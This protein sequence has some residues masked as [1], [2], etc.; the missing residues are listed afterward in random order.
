ML[1]GVVVIRVAL[2]PVDQVYESAP[3]AV[4]VR[5]LPGAIVRLGA[6]VITTDR[7]VP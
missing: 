5:V 3:E 2:T 4:R 6:A 7:D 1:V